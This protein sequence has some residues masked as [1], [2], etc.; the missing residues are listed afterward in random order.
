[1]ETK[2]KASKATNLELP[3]QSV[4]VLGDLH[5]L[6]IIRL[7]YAPDTF[8]ADR[9]THSRIY[10]GYDNSASPCSSSLFAR[11]SHS[12]KRTKN[13]YQVTA[14]RRGCVESGCVRE[15]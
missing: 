1:M 8:T 4:F 11:R 10:R 12:S 13:T 3:E 14:K 6:D 2:I 9:N 15:A 5:K 7:L